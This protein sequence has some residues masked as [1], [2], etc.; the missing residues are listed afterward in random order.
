MR[1][2]GELDGITGGWEGTGNEGGE[3]S[4]GGCEEGGGRDDEDDD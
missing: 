3:R 1:C 4:G 2:E